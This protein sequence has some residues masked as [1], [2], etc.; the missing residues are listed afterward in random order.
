MR[1]CLWLR[2]HLLLVCALLATFCY[3][4]D[5]QITG[6]VTDDK[7]TPLIGATVTVKGTTVVAT[8]D[9]SGKFSIT[10]PADRKVLAISY[11]GMQTREISIG[12]SNLIDVSL[13][14]TGGNMQDVVV[15]GYGNARRANLTGA[16]VGVSAKEIDK[17]INTT[18]EQALQGRA[19]GVYVTQNSGQP[20]GG[21]SVNIRGISSLGRTQPL[22]VIDGVQ[23]Q[24]GE[25]VAFG[26]S[27]TSNVLSGLNPADI[28]DIQ[29]LQG[30][31]A[32][33]IY[34]S[35]ATNGV[36]VITTKRGR[37]GEVKV[38][39][40]FQYGV[41]TPPENLPV[42]NLSQYAQMV[43]EY[44]SIAGGTTPAE[45]LDPSLLGEG[46]DWQKELFNSAAMQKHQLNFSGGANNT[47]YYMSGE[48][49]D[50]DGVAQGSGF[51]R[52][53]FRLNLDNKPRPWA[54]LGLNLNF[55]QTNENLTTTNY[56]DAASPLI[57]NALRLT[58]QI[59][60]KNLNGSWGGADPVN[61]ANQFTLVNPI[62]LA[63]LIT[64]KNQ[65]RQFQGGINLGLTLAKGLTFRTGFYGSIGDG[66]ATYYTP[67]YNIDQWHNNLI[68]SLAN[69]SYQ[70]WY[71]NWNQ[72]LEYTR[73]IKKHNFTLMATHESQESQWKALSVGRT[74]FL[75]N[76]VFDVNAGDAKSATNGGGTY[77]WAMESYLGRLSYNYDNRYLLT[78]TYRSD[79]SPYFGEDKR[80]GSFPSLAVAW[81]INNEQFFKSNTISD[82]KLRYEYGWTG[83][84]GTGSGVYAAMN[85]YATQWDSGFLPATFTN[86]LLQW[87][88]T[89]SNNI[90]LNAGFLNNRFTFEADFYNR[91]TDQLILNAVLPWYMGT[92][93][94]GSVGAPLV[95]AGA[96]DTKGWSFTINSL[97]INNK[98]FRWET[99]LNLSHFKTIVDKLYQATPFI[100]RTSWW[101]N[102]WTQRSYVGQ[103]PWLYMGYQEEGLF[104]SLDEIN[105][106]PVPVDASG[107]RYPTNAQNGLWIGDVKYKDIN[108]DNKID[109]NDMT[110]IGNPWPKLSG[111]FTN[112][113]NYKG[114]ELNI[115]ITGVYGNDVYNYIAAEAS[116]PNNINL[117]R[118]LMAKALE[119]AKITT[120]SNGMPVLA[121]PGTRVPRISNNAISADNNFSRITDRFLEDGS[122]LRIKNISLSY[123]VPAKYLG[124]TKVIKG[125]KA[126]FSAQNIATF[127]SYKGYDPEVGSYIGTGSGGNNQAIGIDFGRYPITPMYIGT[128]SVNF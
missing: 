56:G 11:V 72:Q 5:R 1:K 70:S 55:N 119:Y 107:N 93:G 78:A 27:S 51:K 7:E 42:M 67:T 127:T 13:T 31:S 86:S 110:V 102:N 74:G 6:I 108:G 23:F 128:I 68:A 103:Q 99:N 2:V 123:S 95:N 4:Q 106:S 60:V 33:A 100:S 82:L 63:S 8:T 87:E 84:Q 32:T 118:N 92:N 48:Y 57:A 3:A 101:M 66:M 114:I 15:V 34:G 37:A 10:V 112:T 12:K 75:T 29:I 104:Q 116:N 17:T 109:Q 26:T 28:E 90:G 83:N 9:M 73:Q 20:G 65:K 44:H 120:G 39:Y 125:F 71:W 18:V 36:V 19:A 81:R 47:T 59:P 80:W 64:N 22:Y 53:G 14:P 41:Q 88:E 115:L 52:Y 124:Y 85:T 38:N 16:Q 21:M 77:P 61:G 94:V 98:D 126:T 122:Y 43:G 46:T 62:A 30:P 35:R 121:N 50:Q 69:G 117:S 113:F 49:M 105:K 54:T 91:K 79:G 25:D 97:N 40:L 111:G 58:P 89:K 76:D 45:F 24:V 96:L